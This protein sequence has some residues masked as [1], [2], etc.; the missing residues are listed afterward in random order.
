M[1]RVSDKKR[2][3]KKPIRWSKSQYDADS[4]FKEMMPFSPRKEVIKERRME[5]E[6]VMNYYMTL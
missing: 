6:E 5:K 4:Y 1:G 3:K 2:G